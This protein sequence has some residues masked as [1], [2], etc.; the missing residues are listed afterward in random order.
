M[1]SPMDADTALALLDWQIDLGA[2]EA[3]ADAPVNRFELDPRPAKPTSSPSPQHAVDR[4]AD[5]SA[6]ARAARPQPVSAPGPD[7]VQAAREAARAA[8]DLD[9]LRAALLA[10]PHCDLKKGARNLVFADGAPD[11]RVMIIGEAPGREEDA[12]GLPFVGR[13]GQ[14]LDRMFA[15]IG[16]GRT[17]GAP[18]YITNVIP[19]RPPQSRDPKPEEIAMM[20]PFMQRH[21]EL[22]APDVVVLMGNISCQAGLGRRGIARLRGGWTTAYGRDALPMFPP[23]YLLSNPHAKRDAWQD[24]LA[25]QARL[26]TGNT[27]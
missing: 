4:G 24:L 19:W 11:A 26:A 22:V 9:G 7:P 21:V 2:T 16:M 15:A 12:R 25:L 14:L 6:A 13:E 20:L 18:L 23:A 10:Y 1:E 3:I 17:E 8:G 5:P 27:P